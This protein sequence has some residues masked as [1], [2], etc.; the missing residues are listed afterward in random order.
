MA[1]SL[2]LAR[3]GIFV[4]AELSDLLSILLTNTP[5]PPC[6]TK[7]LSP[8]RKPWGQVGNKT[9]SRNRGPQR[10]PRRGGLVGVAV[11]TARSLHQTPAQESATHGAQTRI[12]CPHDLALATVGAAS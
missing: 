11:G 9:D 12:L 3:V 1:S 8:G 5:V 10:A 4:C 6:G 7:E 2:L